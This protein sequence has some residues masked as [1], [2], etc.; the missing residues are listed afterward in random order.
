[1]VI[2][3][4]AA[5]RWVADA[6]KQ[7]PASAKLR[8]GS[9]KRPL[10]ITCD[11]FYATRRPDLSIE[12]IKDMLE[13]AGVVSDD[14]HIYQEHNYKHFDKLNPRVHIVI[15]PLPTSHAAR[16]AAVEGLQMSFLGGFDDYNNRM[17]C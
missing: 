10:M 14:R 2:K 4:K 1:M 7:I 11:V 16:A 15:E 13:K 3:S 5:R 8:V 6:I 12:L 9:A 17:G